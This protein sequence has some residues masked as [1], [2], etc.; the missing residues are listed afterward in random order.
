[1][2]AAQVSGLSS[3][4]LEEAW[5]TA[6]TISRVGAALALGIGLAGLSAWAFDPYLLKAWFPSLFSLS[7]LT[8]LLLVLSAIALWA[9]VQRSRVWTQVGRGLALV[10]LLGAAQGAAWFDLGI[11]SFLT[12]RIQP[13]GT[14]RAPMPDIVIIVFTLLAI[15]VLLAQTEIV[16]LQSAFVTVTTIALLLVTSAVLPFLFSIESLRT[17]G[18]YA[19]ISLPSTIALTLL[20]FGLVCTRPDLGWMR[21]LSGTEPASREIRSL[22][23]SVIA[24]PLGLAVLLQSGLHAGLYDHSF[25]MPLLLFG[26]IIVLFAALL[27]TASRLRRIDCE[28]QRSLEARQRAENELGIALA[29]AKMAGFQLDLRTGARRRYVRL[30]QTET[31]TY[32]E[33]L[34]AIHPE[35]RARVAQYHARQ[36]QAGTRN[37]QLQYRILD[38][39]EQIGWVLEKGAIR[40]DDEGRAIEISGVTFDITEDV[41]IREALKESEERFKRLAESM[42]QVVYVLGPQGKVRYLN[43]RWREYTG[44][45]TATAADFRRLV[46]AEEFEPLLTRWQSA[47]QHGHDFASEF[48]LRGQDGAYR[49][50]LARAVPV[51][52]SGGEIERWC[53]TLTDIDAQKRAHEELRLVTDN[54]DVYLAHCDKEGRYVFVNKAYTKRFRCAPETLIG[55]RIEEVVGSKAYAMIEPYIRRVLAGEAVSFYIAVPDDES[56][57]RYMYCRYVPDIEPSSGTVRGFVAA[58]SDVTERRALEEQLREADHRKDEF[59]ALLAHELRNPL[60]PIRYAAGLLKPG[61]PAEI[62]AAAH[63]VIERQVA[64]MARL[65]D[66]L[67]DVSRVTRNT[68]ELRLERVDVRKIVTSAVDTVRPLF[69]AVN[70]K[71]TVSVPP[72]PAHVTGDSTRLLQIVG[73]L[74][75]NAAKFTEPGGRIDV[76]VLRDGRSIAIQVKDTGIGIA[77]EFIPKLFDLFVQGDRTQTRASGGLGVG[78]SLAK[79]LVELHEGT[80]E[81]R[82]D[83]VGA[84]STFIVRIPAAAEETT[85]ESRALADNVLPIFQ[86]RHQLLIVDDN[87]DAANSLAILAQL[88]GYVT[89]IAN[90]GLAA[91][92]M[93][94]IVRPEAIIMDLGMPRMSGFE[95]ARWVRQQPWGKDTVLIAVTG[96]GQEE[97]RRRSREAGFDVHLTKPVDSTQ[98]L[99]ELQRKEVYGLK[100]S[101][102]VKSK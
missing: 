69:E 64:H 52:G 101:D 39:R 45:A 33:Y 57:E 81:A 14:V 71:L 98:L 4:S 66:D 47:L 24:L 96:W 40:Y 88:S 56:G 90:D 30:D 17:D 48:R 9:T 67:L 26:S 8:A 31:G 2:G 35:D 11:E 63:D 78:L 46:P 6:G 84:G 99:N 19:E 3:N 13:S 97:D 21:L 16:R 22:A 29:A 72:E 70:H 43:Q 10:T 62:S 76:Q 12:Q 73:N 20:T 54:A 53:G 92:E 95:A 5:P 25:Q 58:I 102:E 59:L 28:R 93:A 7:P 1:M 61:V 37:Y 38:A 49:W 91:I 15:G 80:I 75:N 100:R 83:G 50:F 60:A 86:R 87:L 85:N 27:M 23:I 32:E 94:E 68:L 44:L 41:Q 42:P 89:H 77:P 18:P 79:R 74:L 34:A 51:R 82:S 36:Q 65:V 55:K